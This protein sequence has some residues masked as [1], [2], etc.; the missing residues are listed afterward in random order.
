MLRRVAS[1]DGGEYAG[2]CPWCG[3]VDR[4]HVWPAK[5]HWACLGASAGR[6]GCDR[7]GSAAW[8]I[9][10]RTGAPLERAA[11]DGGHGAQRA[12]VAPPAA[13]PPGAAWQERGW[14]FVFDCQARLMESPEGARARRWLN[15]VRGL[16]D[17]TLSRY[18]I[19][20]NGADVYEAPDVWGFPAEHKRIWLPRGIVIPWQAG[21]E[22]WRI[23]IRRPVGDPKYIGPAGAGNGLFNAD[24]L[25]RGRAVVLVE[26]EF[27]ALTVL[28]L[29]G[30]VGRRTKQIPVAVATGSA[31]GAR[32][33]RWLAQLAA[34]GTVLVAFDA[35]KAGNE[36]ARYWCDVL[37]N[38]RRWRPLWSD[39]ND[40]QRDGA[41]VV[42]WLCA[43]LEPAQAYAGAD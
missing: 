41:D 30:E 37:S 38:A 16:S 6:A 4:L 40:M 39:V 12:P 19:G 3:G 31:G 25:G 26:G 35:D 23:N 32:A 10:L 15:E 29:A 33:I 21:G 1:T 2:P 18:G 43:G 5:D 17:E 20:Y 14:Q 28:Q 8:Y 27:N 34:A 24:E 9:H 11:R 36:G 7:Q 22:L 42:S 13:T